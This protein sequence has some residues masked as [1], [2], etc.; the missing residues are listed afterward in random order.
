MGTG[1]FGRRILKNEVSFVF[2]SSGGRDSVTS[3]SDVSG[4]W[5]RENF[6]IDQVSPYQRRGGVGYLTGS[7]I[8]KRTAVRFLKSPRDYLFLKGS[9][10][11][12]PPIPLQTWSI[13][14][15]E[16]SDEQN[17]IYDHA[18][19]GYIYGHYQ[20]RSDHHCSSQ[21]K[22]RSFEKDRLG[23]EPR[24]RPNCYYLSA[25]EGNFVQLFAEKVGGTQQKGCVVEDS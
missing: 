5:K 20:S 24:I 21:A 23:T 14:L 1:R 25:R 8:E 2:E 3:V 22:Q 15:H 6:F 18:K 19:G 12:S 9:P 4:S 7:G 13:N 17:N 11:F 16:K 10:F